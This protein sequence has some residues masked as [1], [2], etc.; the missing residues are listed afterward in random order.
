MRLSID[1]DK[2]RVSTLSRRL[3]HEGN[4]A[5]RELQRNVDARSA[6]RTRVDEIGLR[7]I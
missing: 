2:S 1:L 4:L 5:G 7:L 6:Y 3:F